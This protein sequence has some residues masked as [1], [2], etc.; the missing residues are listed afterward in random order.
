MKKLYKN[1][2]GKEIRVKMYGLGEVVVPDGV[3]EMEEST[4]D[5]IQRMTYVKLFEEFV[6]EKFIPKTLEAF[7]NKELRDMCEEQGIECSIKDNKA[8]L[9]AKLRGE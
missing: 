8:V 3:F 1:L 6:E 5:A 4:V 7:T 9:L 2:T